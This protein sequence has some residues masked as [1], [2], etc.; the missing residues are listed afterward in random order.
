MAFIGHPKKLNY[1]R[2][3]NLG[4]RAHTAWGTQNGLIV[5]LRLRRHGWSPAEILH[6]L[7]I[8][9]VAASAFAL[10]ACTAPSSRETCLH[11][12]LNQ[13]SLRHGTAV[14]TEI[15]GRMGTVNTSARSYLLA[16]MRRPRPAASLTK[17]IVAKEIRT[18]I[19]AGVVSLDTPIISALPHIDFPLGDPRSAQITL[20]NLLQHTAGFDREKSGDPLWRTANSDCQSAAIYALG[21]RLDLNPGERL[22]YSNAGYCLL[23]ELLK[24]ELPNSDKLLNV[25]LHSTYGA[26]GG[27]VSTPDQLYT[28]LMATMPLIDLAPVATLPDGSYYAF[29]WRHWPNAKTGAPWTHFGRLPG[30][31][32]IAL[33][34]GKQQLLVAF[35]DGDPPDVDAA[36]ERF[37]HLAWKC[38][39]EAGE[40]A[41]RMFPFE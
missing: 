30:I 14:F 7:V 26:A 17:P 22:V 12:A 32:S 24:S 11:D 38:L 31:I 39:G 3:H 4:Y 41:H 35:F 25:T 2:L 23:G 5:Y 34:D 29:A 19:D 10:S 21:H 9:W 28:R 27:W 37:N 15:D 33:T 36:A 40:R 13:P 6:P 1:H 20:R 8:L 18:L 16:L